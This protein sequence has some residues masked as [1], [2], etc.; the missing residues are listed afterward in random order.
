MFK[1]IS[2]IKTDNIEKSESESELS[3]TTEIVNEVVETL[4]DQTVQNT[5]GISDELEALRSSKRVT[6]KKG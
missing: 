4:V 3:E 1:I 6:G 2:S 5:G